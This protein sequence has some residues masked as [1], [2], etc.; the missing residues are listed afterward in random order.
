MNLKMSNLTPT[1]NALSV[2]SADTIAI[3][4]PGPCQHPVGIAN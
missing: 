1:A 3:L 4:L 2:G